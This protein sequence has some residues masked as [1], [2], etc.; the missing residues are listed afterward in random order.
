MDFDKAKIIEVDSSVIGVKKMNKKYEVLLE[1]T[2]C[3]EF[4]INADSEKKAQEIAKAEFDKTVGL[5]QEDYVI[6]SVSTIPETL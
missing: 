1:G 5:Q 4:Y 2:F 3:K 6:D